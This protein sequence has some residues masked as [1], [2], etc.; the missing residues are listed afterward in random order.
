MSLTTLPQQAVKSECSVAGQP[1]RPSKRWRWR[2]LTLIL[3]HVAVIAHIVHWKITGQ[4]ITPVEPSESMQTLEL[5][6]VNAGIILF[7][8]LI[9]STLIFGRF[10]CGW[11]CHVVF[12]QDVCGWV[13][14]KLG[15]KPKPFRSRLL[16]WVPVF[17]ALYMFVWPQ[18]LRIWEGRP[19]PQLAYHLTTENFWATFP[20]P[21]IAVL[22]LAVCGFLAVV[23]LGNKGFCTYGCPYGAFFYNADRFA[24]GKIRVTDA[25]E[26]CGHCTATCTSNVRVHEEVRLYGM[27]V[28]PG[29]MK[30]MDCI[31]VCPKNALYFGFG[32]PSLA[33]K[34]RTQ[35]KRAPRIYDFSWPEEIGLAAAFLIG[36]YAFRGLY[37]SVPFL[38]SIGLSAISAY[39]LLVAA[40][41]IY[42]P[43]ARL[44]R[45]QLKRDGRFTGAGFIY[46]G[47][48][49][50]LAAFM[51][52]STVI[53]NHVHQGNYLLD[54]AQRLFEKSESPEKAGVFARESRNHFLSA[55]SLGIFDVDDWEIKL[56]SLSLFLGEPTDAERHFRAA[57]QL[58]PE[59][60]S[61]HIRLAEIYASNKRSIEALGQLDQVLKRS[62]KHFE[63]L[64]LRGALLSSL[65]RFKEATSDLRMAVQIHPKNARLRSALGIALA[66]SGDRKSG[67][68]ELRK[69][70][71]SSPYEA[72]AYFNL[73]LLLAEGGRKSE[74][75]ANMKTALELDPK[76]QGANAM[77]ARLAIE[78]NKPGQALEYAIAALVEA[79]Y[80]AE[81][82]RIWAKALRL[83]GNLK[84]AQKEF[85]TLP[86]DNDAA[87]YAAAFLY[88]E[89]G[90]AR[91][92]RDL[93]NRVRARLPNLT[94]P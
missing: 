72:T 50:L 33:K 91:T 6:Y 7:S 29:C 84:A 22:T 54:N 68:I 19:F 14:K 20:G 74:A 45:F 49:G 52:Q 67:E 27:V 11:G 31:N 37:N 92:A 43:A 80:D 24:V 53:Q 71:E 41:S 36:F 93:F 81:N 85:T 70:I 15:M 10:F 17:A 5:G 75:L 35:E 55:R 48:A 51:A 13:L 57:T 40:R 44:H 82:L 38:L 8:A 88:K 39:L 86:L 3:I 42:A 94:P 9:L 79:P 16:V 63:A 87:W 2:A 34:S 73:A 59:A 65:G 26:Q 78:E 12:L 69:V 25:C 28:D 76:L 89:A 21:G 56:G 83:T 23:L 1:P 61:A 62:P 60:F 64:R 46:L 58:N 4:T 90:D 32:A 18:V 47:F 77:A 30:C 66:G